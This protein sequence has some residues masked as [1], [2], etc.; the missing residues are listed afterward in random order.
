V[1]FSIWGKQRFERERKTERR[2]NVL[3]FP[4]FYT[5]QPVLATREKQ[6]ELWRQIILKQLTANTTSMVIDLPTYSLF[7]NSKINRSMDLQSRQAVGDSLCQFGQG[8]WEDPQTKTRLRIY[9]KTPEVFASIVYEWAKS[10]AR[11]GEG[12]STF[13]EIHSGE[14]SEGTE[15]MGIHEE[16]LMKALK[17]LEKQNKVQLFPGQTMDETGVKFM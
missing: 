13:Y 15:L 9:S 11:V 17:I 7:T 2:M 1:K 4:P 16:V 10:T 14:D 12:I 6:L 3:D 8:E 5:L